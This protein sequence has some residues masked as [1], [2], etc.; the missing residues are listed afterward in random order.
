[1]F[2]HR[3]EKN[4]I[5]LT[6]HLD[7]STVAPLRKILAEVAHDEVVL[8]LAG[9]QFLSS[10]ILSEFLVASRRLTGRQGRL[11]L[12]ATPAEIR[13]LLELTGFDQILAVEP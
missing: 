7:G 10:E 2:Q 3:V 5:Y 8:D 11:R 1:M 12:A 13:N 4:T 6:G 9:V